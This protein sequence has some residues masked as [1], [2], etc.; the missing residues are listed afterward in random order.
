[1]CKSIE[2]ILNSCLVVT[3]QDWKRVLLTQWPSVVGDL[4]QYM[5]L[6]KIEG[7]V[8]WIGV[9]DYIWMQEL[10][11]LSNHIIRII[12]ERIPAACISRIHV[13]YIGRVVASDKMVLKND[14]KKNCLI[15]KSTKN[16]STKNYSMNT[17]ERAVLDTVQDQE[18]KA[19]IEGFFNACCAQKTIKPS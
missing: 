12:K 19:A 4:T 6:E 1:M 13:R 11:C 9:Y 2:A 14:T 18:L 5:R 7:T 3:T 10:Y 15:H 8:L 16:Y 17:H